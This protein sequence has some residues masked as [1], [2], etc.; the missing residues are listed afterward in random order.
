MKVY[1]N[2][3]WA[4][5]KAKCFIKYPGQEEQSQM[6]LDIF[7]VYS[8]SS[9]VKTIKIRLELASE[10]ARTERGELRRMSQHNTDINS[11]ARPPGA[12]LAHTRH[13]SSSGTLRGFIQIHR[14]QRLAATLTTRGQEL[15]VYLLMSA[16]WEREKAKYKIGLLSHQWKCINWRFV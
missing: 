16:L 9:W 6:C 14:I 1:D 12:G 3:M 4:K 2:L 13:D 8:V 15:T 11:L 10:S 5:N 7:I